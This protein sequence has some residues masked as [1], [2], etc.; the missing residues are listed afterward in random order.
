MELK[1]LTSAEHPLFARAM[2]GY[3]VSFPLHEQ[4]ERDSQRAIMGHP[5]Y[6]FDLILEG[7]ALLGCLLYWEIGEF[8]Y[9][10][11]FFILPEKRNGGCGAQALELLAG[12]G[13]CVIL[14]IDPVVDEISRRRKGFYERCGFVE[15]PYPHVHPPYH[16]G[17][18]G[19]SLV[20]MSCPEELS[21]ELYQ[22]F[23]HHLCHTVMGQ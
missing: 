7:E 11:H 3:G 21:E 23:F 22:K 15:N 10:E 18:K 5:E 17:N 1:R 12:K 16:A 14:E 20:V 13:K 6:H 19:H 8:I 4:R 9:V 2:E